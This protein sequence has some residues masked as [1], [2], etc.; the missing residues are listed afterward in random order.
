MSNVMWFLSSC[1]QFYVLHIS[2]Q[3]GSEYSSGLRQTYPWTPAASR[4]MLDFAGCLLSSSH[5]LL[6]SV[7][8]RKSE[9]NTA[10]Q[11]NIHHEGRW[12]ICNHIAWV[13]GSSLSCQQQER[14]IK[15][16]DACIRGTWRNHRGFSSEGWQWGQIT[17]KA[18]QGMHARWTKAPESCQAEG[19]MVV[20][21]TS[22]LRE[23]CRCL[24]SCNWE[25]FSTE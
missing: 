10:E 17:A 14:K 3:P 12:G 24:D 1:T 7:Y 4:V 23:Y 15:V 22:W 21:Q 19:P 20:S 16:K 8:W 6:T 9:R 25:K 13:L 11:I 5:A 2:S 18:E